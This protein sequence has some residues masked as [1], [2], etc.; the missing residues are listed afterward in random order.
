MEIVLVVGFRRVVCEKCWTDN[1]GSEVLYIIKF[2]YI[3]L[4][5]KDSC[6]FKKIFFN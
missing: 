6:A 5:P 1:T 3:K 2:P 4:P